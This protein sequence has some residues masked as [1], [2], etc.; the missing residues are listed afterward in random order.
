MYVASEINDMKTIIRYCLFLFLLIFTNCDNREWANP[1]DPG[2]PKEIFTPTNFTAA[3]DG[4]EII[5]SW[6]QTNPNIT[7]FKIERQVENESFSVLA[8]PGK[9]ETS[10]TNT[11]SAGGKLHTY[12]LYALAGSNKSNEVTAS[13]TPVLQASVTTK[14]VTEITDSSAISG[15]T[16][17]DDGGSP[18]TARGVVWSIT[19]S[20]TLENNVGKTEN[21]SG[22]GSF[23]SELTALEENTNYFVRAYATNSRGTVYG[24]EMSFKTSNSATIATVATSEV[25][26]TTSTTALL[27][28]NVIDDGNAPVTERGVCYCLAC[29]TPTIENNKVVVGSGVGEFSTTISGLQPNADYFYRAYAINSQ[30]IAYGETVFFFPLPES[31]LATVSTFTPQNIVPGAA[32]LGGEITE[33]GASGIIERGVCWSTSPSPVIDDNKAIFYLFGG[34]GI[35]PFSREI[36]GFLANTTYFVRAFATN[37]DGTAYGQEENWT[38]SPEIALPAVTTNEP[39]GITTN[40]AVLGGHVDNT[41]GTYVNEWGIV[42]GT[43]SNPTV[44]DN[45]F[46]IQNTDINGGSGSIG[47]TISELNAGTNYYVRAYAINS[48]GI[49]YGEQRS[50][51]TKSVTEETVTDIEGNVYQTVTIN[52]QVWMAEN[53]KTTKY[54][55]G[56]FIP[57]VTGNTTWLQLTSGAFCWCYNDIN[58]KSTYGALYNWFAVNSRK[59]CPE[60]WHVPGDDEWTLLTEY[61]GGEGVAGGKMKSTTGWNSPNTGATD[62]S[63]FSALPGGYRFGSGEF[64]GLGDYGVWWSKTENSGSFVLCRSLN[65]NSAFVYRINYSKESGFSVR[66]VKD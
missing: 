52:G 17:T 55:D 47:V 15:G 58:N 63:R 57:N 36:T 20:P 64:T 34:D 23:I 35:E 48:Q 3:Q 60:G 24:N 38:T 4:D 66:C 10:A 62:S 32:T 51:T 5:L 45:K 33:T 2:C 1:F 42:Y 25:T 9:N 16:I 18:V 56:T 19:T 37:G 44:D 61:L 31:R 8:S 29:E 54:N 40:S 27:G 28:G 12:K 65:Y 11:I 22:T 6:N 46:V 13:I 21:G 41:G 59:L 39:E 14:A 50:F 26:T 53:L 43:S 30:G 49:G 7:G